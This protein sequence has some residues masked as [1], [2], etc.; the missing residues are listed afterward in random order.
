MQAMWYLCQ[1]ELR[2]ETLIIKSFS[3]IYCGLDFTSF[4]HRFGPITIYGQS[5]VKVSLLGQ[6]LF[7]KSFKSNISMKPI[8]WW[9]IR[10]FLLTQQPNTGL[11]HPHHKHFTDRI[12]AC[13]SVHSEQ[14][15]HLRVGLGLS[16]CILYFSVWVTQCI[17]VRVALC[18][19]H[20]AWQARKT[21]SNILLRNNEAR[22]IKGSHTHTSVLLIQSQCHCSVRWDLVAQ[23][24]SLEKACGKLN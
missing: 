17:C 15:A 11:S 13:V 8:R 2:A 18:M 14:L 5:W 19:M 23:R 10:L 1:V 4:V 24:H 21:Q 22:F 12:C 16:T 20:S 9:P 3:V 6:S 7:Y